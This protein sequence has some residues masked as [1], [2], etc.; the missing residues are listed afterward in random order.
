MTVSDLA[1]I[2][3]DLATWLP[4]A[5]QLTPQHDTTNT[6]GRSQ[7]ESRPPWNQQAATALLDA[8]ETIRR[9]EQH[10]R[11]LVTGRP[12]PRR[13]HQATPAMLADMPRLAQ[14]LETTGEQEVLAAITRNLRRCLTAILQL[15]AIG[16]H[17]PRRRIAAPCPYC[18]TP[19]LIAAPR[20]GRITC[21]DPDCEDTT[22]RHPVGT[23]EIG[24]LS[25]PLIAWADGLIMN[26]LVTA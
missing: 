10:I 23:V 7:T 14:A 13:S 22:G 18:G 2:C 8:L 6:S 11:T 24:T 21:A 4:A 19:A 26:T 15:P 20:S 5:A 3:D 1:A 16:E 12:A 17:E 9:S 25:G